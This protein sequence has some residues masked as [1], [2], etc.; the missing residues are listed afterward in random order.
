MGCR[1]MK[2]LIALRTD[3]AITKNE[4]ATLEKHLESC[5]ECS[6]E[7]VLQ[8]RICCTLREDGREEMEAP[9][10]LCGMVMSK[11][12]SE[13]RKSLVWLPDAWRKTIAA[14]AA[15]LLLAG[16]SAG[17]TAGLKLAGGGNMVAEVNVS[18]NDAPVLAD[19]SQQ[20]DTTG[21][22]ATGSV[23]STDNSSAGPKEN[24]AAGTSSP[25]STGQPAASMD[26]I[27]TA[28]LSS[29]LKVTS[30]I[31]KTAVDDMAGARAKAVALAAGSGASAQVF[32]EQ[33]GGRSI[34]VIRIAAPADSAT[35]LIRDLSGIGSLFD[36]ADESR[37]LTALY[38]ETMV[39]YLDLQSRIK[40][41]QNTDERPLMETQAA[42]YKAQ[43]DAWDA[44][45]G[46]QIITLWLESK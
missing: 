35:G 3:G 19:V 41:S 23:T 8:E 7:L 14:A 25:L 45:A 18:E 6:R 32:P 43:L 31:L 13:R 17:V 27:H 10:E 37:D 22:A 4:D 44:E 46:K 26:P 9:P 33:F 39:R 28:L 24:P 40:T 36:R 11:L 34:V 5:G 20:P 12:R 15:L 16:G 29:E 21:V 38:N 42:A 30:T 1:E 2:L